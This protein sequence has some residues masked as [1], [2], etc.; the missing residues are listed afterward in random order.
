MARL[1]QGIIV[2]HKLMKESMIVVNKSGGAGRN[3][4]DED[5]LE[6]FQ[7]ADEFM[8]AVQKYF[9]N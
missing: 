2:K 6:S 5:A 4:S 7:W 1:I 8:Q 9:G 3:V